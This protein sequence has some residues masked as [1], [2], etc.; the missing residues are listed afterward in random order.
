[1]APLGRKDCCPPARSTRG[2]VSAGNSSRERPPNSTP[3]AWP[4]PGASSLRCPVLRQ[5]HHHCPP[6]AAPVTIVSPPD[7]PGE[8]EESPSSNTYR[9]LAAPK[10]P[11]KMAA[12]WLTAVSLARSVILPRAILADSVRTFLGMSRGPKGSVQ[13]VHPSART[14]AGWSC[15][16]TRGPI[17]P[18]HRPHRDRDPSGS[19]LSLRTLSNGAQNH[20]TWSLRCQ[21]KVGPPGGFQ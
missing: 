9:F 10:P 21:R 14:G 8:K 16:D 15:P 3:D 6:T 18:A 17:L 13:T 20:H 2:R 1:M 11:G 7:A 4:G 5:L 19:T 12:S